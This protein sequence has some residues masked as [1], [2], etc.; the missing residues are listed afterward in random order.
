MPSTSRLVSYLVV[1]VLVLAVVVVLPATGALDVPRL[2]VNLGEIEEARVVEVVLDELRE[3]ERGDVR[4]QVVIVEVAAGQVEI[5]HVFVEGSA[6]AFAMRTGD[7]ILV[8]RAEFNGAERYFVQERQRRSSVWVLSLA[9]ALLVVLIGGRQG[10]MSLVALGLSFLVIVR[11]IVPAIY[12]GWDP[13]VAA[14]VGALGFVA[15]TLYLHHGPLGSR[16]RFDG[17]LRFRIDTD[18]S[19]DALV[20]DLLA[21]HCARSQ[22]LTI[23]EVAQGRLIEHTYQVKFGR[24]RDRDAL[25]RALREHAHVR[26]ARLLLQEVTLEY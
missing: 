6:G 5:E 26:D 13:V 22:A 1:A 2:P 12:G 15:V 17:V 4:T 24:D 16:A 11:F 8:S 21:R 18:N 25:L 7:E 14:I 20:S 3:T 19:D 23:G 9:F 10:A